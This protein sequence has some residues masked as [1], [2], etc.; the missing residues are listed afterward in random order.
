LYHIN[1]VYTMNALRAIAPRQRCMP[2][3]FIIRGSSGQCLRSN[4]AP[5]TGRA[6]VACHLLDFLNGEAS[7][8]RCWAASSEQTRTVHGLGK[9]AEFPVSRPCYRAMYLQ[10]Q[11]VAGS[12]R[13]HKCA[14]CT[15]HAA[16]IPG[17]GVCSSLRRALL[18]ACPRCV[19]GGCDVT[20]AS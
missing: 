1:G 5:C 14:S 16:A 4:S 17:P 7:S 20:R 11:L 2:Y 18:A 10:L 13:R 15:G 9:A 8:D 19:V 12:C 3:V 6:S